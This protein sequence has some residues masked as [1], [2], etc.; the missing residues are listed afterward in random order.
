VADQDSA[1][2]YL[3]LSTPWFLTYL[4]RSMHLVSFVEQPTKEP[5]GNNEGNAPLLRRIN[6]ARTTKAINWR[7]IPNT[8]RSVTTHFHLN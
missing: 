8:L 7:L 3:N 1:S 5:F 6:P 2:L 4:R